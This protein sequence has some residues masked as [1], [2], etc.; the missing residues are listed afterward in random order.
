M[1][2]CIL[3][4]S[5]FAL[6]FSLPSPQAEIAIDTGATKAIK[7]DTLLTFYRW[8]LAPTRAHKGSCQQWCQQ[9]YGFTNRVVATCVVNPQQ[10]ASWQRHNQAV[11]TQLKEKW[12]NNWEEDFKK[13]LAQCEAKK[14]NKTQAY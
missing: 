6:A 3:I 1:K 13:E 2:F 10:L 8:G 7:T 4:I 5:I 14:A 9:K 12:G 11:S